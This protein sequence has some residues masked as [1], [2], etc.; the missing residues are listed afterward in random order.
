M[1]LETAQALA[2]LGLLPSRRNDYASEFEMG[3]SL[4]DTQ[5]DFVKRV[6]SGLGIGAVPGH[7][8][9]QGPRRL[10]D[11]GELN[12][13]RLVEVPPGE[14]EFTGPLVRILDLRSD[15]N[16]AQYATISFTVLPVV[17]NADVNADDPNRA[18]PLLGIIEF[19]NG[20]GF[21][22]VE[23]DIQRS[24]S[25]YNGGSNAFGLAYNI[26]DPRNY[27]SPPGGVSI[28]V[29]ASSLR[30]FARNDGNLRPCPNSYIL[31][32][33]SVAGKISPTAKVMAHIAYGL[34]GIYEGATRT[35]WLIKNGTVSNANTAGFFSAI[36]PFARTLV[37]HRS[38]TAT[39]GIFY[40][41][42]VSQKAFGGSLFYQE[43][44]IPAGTVS[45]VIQVPHGATSISVK[46]LGPNTAD[47]TIALVYGIGV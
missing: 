13:G 33:P 29:P 42:Q 8:K 20:S 21:S 19:G 9:G 44:V 35:V 5:S 26:D 31:N 17:E 39:M 6:K 34:R 38:P 23:V 30:V 3:S 22:R 37:I 12:L 25:P 4:Q 11:N 14:R 47:A 28:S 10:L 40:Q 16:L 1:E 41:F 24:A 45:P 7:R 36:P 15:S 32:E 27:F 46:N 18:G 2:S 43:E